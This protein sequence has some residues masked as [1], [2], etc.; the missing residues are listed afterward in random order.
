MYIMNNVTFKKTICTSGRKM[1]ETPEERVKLLKAGFDG[2]TIE[3]L[4][5]KYNNLKI[6]R[7]PEHRELNL[8]EFDLPQVKTTCTVSD[9]ETFL[10]FFPEES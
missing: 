8:N 6:V 4:Y 10:V 1:L 9:A 7:C 3:E 5:I 2:K